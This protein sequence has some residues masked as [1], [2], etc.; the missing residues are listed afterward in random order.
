VLL[1]ARVLAMQRAAGN[2]AVVR[3][4]ARTS[5]EA[6]AEQG[7]RAV[8]GGGPTLALAALY[9]KDQA[10]RNATEYTGGVGNHL[11]PCDALRHCSWSALVMHAALKDDDTSLLPNPFGTPRERA[12]KVLIAHEQAEGGTGTKDSAMD[13]ANNETG[14]D[15]AER[16]FKINKNITRELLLQGARKE[17]DAGSLLM[18]DKTGN[19][20]STSG[21]RDVDPETWGYDEQGNPKY[22]DAHGNPIA[23]PASATN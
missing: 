13:Q 10:W 14:M 2:A 17:L 7:A 18:F 5:A 9:V 23:R 21:W 6:L 16:M 3:A 20:I 19:F 22:L 4:L 11:G 12:Y 15:M 1:P 8:A